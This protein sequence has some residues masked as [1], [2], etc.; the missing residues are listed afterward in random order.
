M[1]ADTPL[2]SMHGV[3]REVASAKTA[4]PP[5]GWRG[6]DYTADFEKVSRSVACCLSRRIDDTTLVEISIYDTNSERSWM[7][8]LRG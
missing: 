1:A 2:A 6:A 3:R 4:R 8:P 7:T 5:V